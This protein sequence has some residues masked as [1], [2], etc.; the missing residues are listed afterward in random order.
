MRHDATTP[1]ATEAAP[2]A[3]AAAAGVTVV[4]S[5]TQVQISFRA[6]HTPQQA[7]VD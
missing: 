7:T 1:D 5:I 3:A 4:T 6:V 2:A